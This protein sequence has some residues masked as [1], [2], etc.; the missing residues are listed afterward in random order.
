MNRIVILFLLLAA[1]ARSAT[2]GPAD[3]VF[4]PAV[5]Y[6]EHEIDFKYGGWKARGE[7]KRLNAAS[8]GYGY[9]VTQNWFTEIYSKY[10]HPGGEA[11][12]FDAFEWENKFALTEPGQYFLDTGF[13]VEMERPSDRS[14][15]YELRFGPLFQKD[16]G[17]VQL[18]GNLLF[19]RQYRAEVMQ[20]MQFGY[21]W[22]A[23]YR[24]KPALELGFQGFGEFG[25]W[26]HW[27]PAEQRS[28][29]LGPAVFGRLALG[30]HQAIRYNAA[31]LVRA[32]TN[33][34]ADNFRMQVEYEF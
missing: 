25:P 28:H 19:E 11:T 20:P 23:K 8:I 17:K 24:W 14:E 9:G 13:I 15:G 22:Q 26:N 21:Q 31:W 2:A 30:N 27:E 12:R 5:T 7:E 16:L 18:N 32:S 34:P 29:R 33:A 3:Y 6:A 1:F 10:E 4:T